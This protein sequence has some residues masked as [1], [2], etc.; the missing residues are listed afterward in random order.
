MRV[1]TRQLTPP[2]SISGGDQLTHP[3][4]YALVVGSFPVN[5]S[6]LRALPKLLKGAGNPRWEQRA[7]LLF[8]DFCQGFVT[9]HASREGLKRTS[10]IE[11]SHNL[12]KLATAVSF[13][14]QITMGDGP[15]FQQPA[16]SCK[17][18]S[19]L[20]GRDTN[21]FGVA[22]SVFINCIEAKHPQIRS[23]LA[24]M[25]VQ[26]EFRLAQDP[27]ADSKLRSNVERFEH[28]VSGD[29]I[30]ALDDIGEGNRLTVYDY[31]LNLGVRHA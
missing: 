16:V 12:S 18:Y 29:P 13:P 6:A 23:E 17:Q 20:L 30:A 24:Q 7:H 28:R 14:H 22:E 8:G 25:D 26:D 11:A 31:Q 10:K 9:N 15:I 27:W 3:T 4:L 2:G 21:Q 19:M 5:P 1:A